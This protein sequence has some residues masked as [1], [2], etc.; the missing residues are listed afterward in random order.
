MPKVEVPSAWEKESRGQKPKSLKKVSKK[1]PGAGSQ[2][3][4]KSLEKGPKSQ[5]KSLKMGFLETFRTFF[6]TFFGLLGPGPGRLFRD[7][8]ETF[9]LLAPRLLLPGR[10]NLKPKEAPNTLA[11]LKRAF[12]HAR[13]FLKRAVWPI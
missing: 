12:R 9:W 11:F 5:K 4:E 2:K 3:S 1:S 7:F 6:E 13:P 10:R 8:F